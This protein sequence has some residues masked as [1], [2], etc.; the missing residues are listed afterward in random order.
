MGGQSAASEQDVRDLIRE[1]GSLRTDLEKGFS[2]IN[3]TLRL[4]DVPGLREDVSELQRW[5]AEVGG[6]DD[7]GGFKEL[8]EDVD[9]LK[10]WKSEQDGR[11][12]FVAAIALGWGA[13]QAFLGWVKGMGP[14]TI[15][16][17]P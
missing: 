9:A 2:T 1:I 12:K 11:T 5:R 13:V 3:T 14:H 16:R 7:H 8:R 15:G 4:D 6:R 17:H 10:S